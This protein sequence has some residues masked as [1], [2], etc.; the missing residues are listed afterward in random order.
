MIIKDYNYYHIEIDAFR[1][2]NSNCLDRR[3]FGKGGGGS[4]KKMPVTQA[5]TMAAKVPTSSQTQAENQNKRLAASMLTN[6]WNTPILGKSTLIGN[7]SLT[8][9]TTLGG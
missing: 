5:S 3:R 6:E 2:A 7:N 9:K 8:G 4:T 1:P